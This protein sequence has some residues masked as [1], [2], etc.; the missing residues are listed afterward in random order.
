LKTTQ[1][2]GRD[3]LTS[4]RPRVASDKPSQLP[5]W[6]MA[7]LKSYYFEVDNRLEKIDFVDVVKDTKSAAGFFSSSPTE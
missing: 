3:F 4:F 2:L 5:L 1:Q 7:A 6:V